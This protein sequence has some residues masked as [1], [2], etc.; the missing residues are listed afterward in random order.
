MSHSM[1]L[2]LGVSGAIGTHPTDVA[3][4]PALT[5]RNRLTSAF[6]C[7]FDIRQGRVPFGVGPEKGGYYSERSLASQAQSLLRMIPL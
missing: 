3:V 4:V 5:H 1:Q 7:R 6:L 2:E